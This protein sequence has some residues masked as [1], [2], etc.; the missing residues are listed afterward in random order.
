VDWTQRLILLVVGSW[1]AYL[2][3][4]WLASL[5]GRPRPVRAAAPTPELPADVPP[6]VLGMLVNACRVDPDAAVATLMDLAARKHI[7]FLEPAGEPENTLVRVREARPEGL[8]AYE[9]RVMDRV[10]QA[11]GAAGTVSLADLSNS[12]AE[13]GFRWSSEFA[14]EVVADAKER[15]LTRAG[16][17]G[18]AIIAIILGFLLSCLTAAALPTL[19]W[20]PPTDANGEVSTGDGI[21]YFGIIFVLMVVL[22]LAAILPVVTWFDHPHRTA[23]GRAVTARGLGLSR[24]LR[25]HESFTELPPAAVAVWDRYLSY[26][27]ALG[28][29]A[30]VSRVADLAVG[31]REVLWSDYGGGWRQ[32]RVRYRRRGRSSGYPPMTVSVYAVLTLGAVAGAAWWS[33]DWFDRQ[34][35]TTRYLLLVGLALV[36]GRAMYRLIRAGLDRIRPV[37][38]TGIVLTRSGLPNLIGMDELVKDPRLQFLAGRMQPARQPYFV[39][40]DDGHSDVTPVWTVYPAWRGGGQCQPGDVV[41]LR[42]YRWCRYARKISVIRP[43]AAPAETAVA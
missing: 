34:P 26:G 13:D 39:V 20:T 24:W 31:S 12:Y 28:D 27:A 11:A 14:K 8:T 32:V 22:F 4:S 17:D 38:F 2:V 19:V 18:L 16:P 37:E 15:G 9:R 30:V 1:A 25:A 5:L 10:V 40:V 6:A 23:A 3:L 29:T 21:L 43:A 35:A 36:A 7:E 33:R 41:R 42:G